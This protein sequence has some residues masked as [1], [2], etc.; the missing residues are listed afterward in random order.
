MRTYF[1]VIKQKQFIFCFFLFMTG[2]SL[3]S[4][5]TSNYLS[6]NP[7]IRYRVVDCPVEIRES[8]VS[9]ARKYIERE[10]VWAWGGRDYL[11]EEGILSL[12]CSGFIVRIF[13]YAVKG[14]K[15]SLLFEDAPISAL[16]EYFTVPVDTLTP[17]DLIFMGTEKNAPPTHISV[18][19]EMDNENIYFMDATLKEEDE[20]NGVTLRHYSR[21]DPRFLYY[22]RLLIKY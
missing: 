10:T 20:I 15:Y 8:A 3:F 13:Q 11:E 7:E 2:L 19:T 9:Y 21:D 16:C 4:C 17:G 1:F 22:A 5:A 14:T 12:D 6:G 18:F